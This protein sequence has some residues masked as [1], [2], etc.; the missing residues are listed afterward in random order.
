MTR[1]GANQ[2]EYQI[3]VNLSSWANKRHMWQL[4]LVFFLFNLRQS[5][6]RQISPRKNL[7]ANWL[8]PGKALILF[9]LVHLYSFVVW[10]VYFTDVLL[11]CHSS[12]FLSLSSLSSFLHIYKVSQIFWFIPFFNARPFTVNFWFIA[13]FVVAVVRLGKK[14]LEATRTS[15]STSNRNPNPIHGF[16]PHFI[17]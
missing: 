4:P 12:F 9:G 15:T 16:F 13:F 3:T 17:A 8:R 7:L 10:Y 1:F 11:S 14:C 5:D 2:K 6:K